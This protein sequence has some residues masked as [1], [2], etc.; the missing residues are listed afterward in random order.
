[1]CNNGFV[2]CE[3]GCRPALDLDANG[4]DDCAENLI[5]NGQFTTDA[6]SWSGDIQWG[7]SDANAQDSGSGRVFVG[8]LD[9]EAAGRQCVVVSPSTSYALWL[10]FSLVPGAKCTPTVRVTPFADGACGGG[11]G[12]VQA[13]E[14]A[15]LPES[16]WHSRPAAFATPADAHSVLIQLVAVKV[17]LGVVGACNVLWDNVV[18]HP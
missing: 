11:A 5:R 4:T 3:G 6:A 12:A 9:D 18:L 13:T 17:G 10:M 14:W 16:Q 7:N 8:A 15:D 1:M 2:P